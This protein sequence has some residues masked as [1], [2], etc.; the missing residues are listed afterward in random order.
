MKLTVFLVLTL[1]I[2]TKSDNLSQHINK[3][4]ELIENV[5]RDPKYLALADFQKL[6]VL[7][8][9]YDII[10]NKVHS[11]DEID[12]R[13]EKISLRLKDDKKRPSPAKSN[14]IFIG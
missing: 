3:K 11:S 4:F 9:L 12:Q 7:T 5:V 13:N 10:Q 8:S 2:V 6:V 1:T 14:R